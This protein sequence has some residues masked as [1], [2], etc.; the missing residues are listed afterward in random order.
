MI[1]RVS[2]YVPQSSPLPLKKTNLK[3]AKG[4]FATGTR[5]TGTSVRFLQKN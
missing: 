3:K 5:A 1:L 2:T 4:A